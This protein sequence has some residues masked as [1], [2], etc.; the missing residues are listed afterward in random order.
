MNL[1]GYDTVDV[2]EFTLCLY[3]CLMCSNQKR[4]IIR[5]PLLLGFVCTAASLKSMIKSPKKEVYDQVDG[6]SCHD[7]LDRSIY[8]Y[9]LCGSML[10]SL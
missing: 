10:V 1:S 2:Y 6:E 7:R 8:G 4:F 3:S 5:L 9:Q